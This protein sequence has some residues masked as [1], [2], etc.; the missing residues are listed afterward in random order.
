M[1]SM[2]ESERKEIEINAVGCYLAILI[3]GGIIIYLLFGG[4]GLLRWLGGIKPY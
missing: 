3:V 1:A 2:P 4:E